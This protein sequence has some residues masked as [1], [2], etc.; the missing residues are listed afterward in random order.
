MLKTLKTLD[1][2]V[3][4]FKVC[5]TKQFAVPQS[6]SRVYLLAIAA[7]VCRDGTVLQC[8]NPR[9]LWICTSFCGKMWW[10]LRNWNPKYERLLGQ[11]LW[12]KGYVLDVGASEGFQSVMTNCC[13]CLTKTRLGQDGDYIPKLPRLL[14]SE[15]ASLQGL[16]SQ[17]LHAMQSAASEH[18]LPTRTIEK[19]LGGAMSINVVAI[20]LS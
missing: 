19:S 5:D 4:D 3:V 10:D 6:R 8:H 2:Y 15:A 9:I 14:T 7:E 1:Y 20:V 18:G 13:P 11:K 16:P 12:T 17:V